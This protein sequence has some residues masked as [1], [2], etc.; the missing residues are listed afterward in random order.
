MLH[1]EEIGRFETVVEVGFD[2]VIS[3]IGSVPK[4]VVI[5]NDNVVL[6][7]RMGFKPKID[8]LST[9]YVIVM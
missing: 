4:I 2:E 6:N 9:G 1:S 7:S 3:H 8:F 5:I